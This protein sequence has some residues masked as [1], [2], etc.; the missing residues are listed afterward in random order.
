MYFRTERSNRRFVVD[1]RFTHL[2]ALGALG[3]A[4]GTA[5]LYL[6]LIYFFSPTVTGGAPGARGGIDHVGWYALIVAMAVPVA[7]LAGVHVAFARQ[8][9]DGPK[10]MH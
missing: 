3:V 7:L 6:V 8:L 10:P 5:V 2:A 1:K 9:R 4:G